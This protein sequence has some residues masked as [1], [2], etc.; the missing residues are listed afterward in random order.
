MNRSA[1]EGLNLLASLI[2]SGINLAASFLYFWIV[3]FALLVVFLAFALTP[4]GVLGWIIVGAVGLYLLPSVFRF[5]EDRIEDTGVS[6]A[7]ARLQRASDKIA[8]GDFDGAI[9]VLEG[10]FRSRAA[11]ALQLFLLR[12]RARHGKRDFVGVAR[13]CESALDINESCAQAYLLR[14]LARWELGDLTA[15]LADF[16]TALRHEPSNADIYLKRGFVLLTE[17]LGQRAL[18]DFCRASELA[19]ETSVRADALTLQALAAA[20][21][22]NFLEAILC[23]NDVVQSRPDDE[24]AVLLRGSCLLAKRDFLPAIR[25]FR[26]ARALVAE[27]DKLDAVIFEAIARWQL[28]DRDAAQEE[29]RAAYSK[30]ESQQNWP[31]QVARFLLDEVDEVHLASAFEAQKGLP[32][33]SAA[34]E[35]HYFIAIRQALCGNREMAVQHLLRCRAERWQ[36]AVYHFLA[37]SE[38]KALYGVQ[39]LEPLEAAC[40]SAEELLQPEDLRRCMRSPEDF[41]RLIDTSVEVIKQNQR[42]ST[43]LLQ[44]CLRISFPLALAVIAELERQ[45]FVGPGEGAKPRDIIDPTLLRESGVEVPPLRTS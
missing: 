37:V 14:A 34:C 12:A 31:K 6:R 45:G 9:A 30:A 7:Q 35:M 29:L 36:D 21:E 32:D 1:R 10:K 5:F 39:Y 44:R 15:A 23:L 40:P 19:T 24:V 8:S 42:A 33:A 18:D 27:H 11:D 17:R 4:Y 3:G 43:A 28:G 38:L 13:D 2:G 25:D 41:A 22:F 26:S 16:E 20:W